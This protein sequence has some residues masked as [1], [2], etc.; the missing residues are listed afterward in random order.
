LAAAGRA[1]VEQRF[2]WAAAIDRLERVL[3]HVAERP[4]SES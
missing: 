2:S 1:L 3:E 4:R